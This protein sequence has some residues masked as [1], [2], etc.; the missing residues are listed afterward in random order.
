MM[1][2][3]K[4]LIKGFIILFISVVP[5]SFFVVAMDPYQFFKSDSVFIEQERFQIPGLARNQVFD[6][7]VIGTSMIENFVDSEVSDTLSVDAIKLPLNASYVTEQGMIIDMAV[8]NNDLKNIIWNIDYRCID[9]DYG[10]FYEKEIEFPK[11][12]Y[13]ELI[14]ND[15][16]YVI[17]HSNLF[18][19]MKK[20]L[21]EDKK[22]DRFNEFK[23]D[24]DS[25]NSWY[26]WQGFGEKLLIEDYSK[27]KSGEKDL[28]DNLKLESNRAEIKKVI[29]KE[30]VERI[31]NYDDIHF[32]LT[33]PPKSILW[34][35]L[36]DEK[37]ILDDKEFAQLYLLEKVNDLEN[38][39]VY[40]FQNA[41]DI[42]ENFEIYHDLN[43]YNK[44]GNDYMLKSIK[45]KNHITD[46]VNYKSEMKDL[47]SHIYSPKVNDFLNK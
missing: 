13:D 17:N 24:L 3:K 39:D 34:F 5:I 31:A 18:L 21:Y 15:W 9:I 19:S 32:S 1:D 43:H 16:R 30:I 37:G 20:L 25:L 40:N 27:M 14:Y 12:M 45:D 33:F 6:T 44:S 22:S 10:E 47:K 36:L 23:T 35:R 11:Y 42:T 8:S 2:L 28:N 38:V 7:A 46:K 29:D 26:S 4:I 41:Y